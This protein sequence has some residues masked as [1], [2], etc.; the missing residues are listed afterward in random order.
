MNLRT[1]KSQNPLANVRTNLE[2]KVIGDKE[3]LICSANIVIPTNKKFLS[4]DSKSTYNKSYTA[5][6]IELLTDDFD[7][8]ALE[9]LTLNKVLSYAK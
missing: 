3:Y 8:E 7:Y 4:A 5:Q 6:S 1:L 2:I 9:E